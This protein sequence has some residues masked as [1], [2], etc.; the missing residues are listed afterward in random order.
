M[1]Y[2]PEQ[3]PLL[4]LIRQ[5]SGSGVDVCV[6]RIYQDLET[7]NVLPKLW[8]KGDDRVVQVS[9]F[10]YGGGFYAT[11]C[12]IKPSNESTPDLGVTVMICHTSSYFKAVTYSHAGDCLY[13]TRRPD[14]TL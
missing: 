12:F 11:G 9:G 7:L 2:E 8:L 14:E 3:G 5:A 13:Q 4:D 1:A 6:E 10:D